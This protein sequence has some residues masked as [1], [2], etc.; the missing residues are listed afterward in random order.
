LRLA[1]FNARTAVADKRYFEGLPSPSAAAAV[2]SFVWLV[3]EFDV[4]GLPALALAFAI[5][6]CIGALMV[7]R[8]SYWSGKELNIRGRIPWVYAALIPLIYVVISLSPESLFAL[9]GTYALSAPMYW[10]WRKLFRRK[11]IADSG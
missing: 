3:S 2:A 8:F 5:T 10:A 7:S 6:I 11:R 9:F 4:T 1:R